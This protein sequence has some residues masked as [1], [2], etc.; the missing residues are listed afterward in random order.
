M[1]RSELPA[2]VKRASSWFE[3]KRADYYEYFSRVLSSSGGRIKPRQILQKD[4]DRFAGKPRGTL[5]QHWF[6]R[7]EENGGDLSDAFE[8][9]FPDDE[10]AVLRIAQGQGEGSLEKALLDMAKIA[11][12][13]QA[14]VKEVKSTV[15][16][17]FFGL[18]LAALMATLFPI[19]VATD[20]RKNYGYIPLEL[21]GPKAKTL[22]AYTDFLQAWGIVVLILL[23]A[24]A[25][26]FKWSLAG[27]IGELRTV[28]DRKIGIYR[29]YRDIKCASFMTTMATLTARNGTKSR[30]MLQAIELFSQSI[31]TP[32]LSWRVNATRDLIEELGGT[33]ADSFRTPMISDD[34]FYYLQDMQEASGLEKGFQD[35]ARYIDDA[36]IPAL[37]VRLIFYRYLI[38]GFA[39]ALIIFVWASNF[40]IMREMVGVMKM[41]QS[42]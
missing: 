29:T 13:Q 18:I 7:I 26:L 30:T 16:V 41:F 35:T 21:W 17:A 15:Y 10:I 11:R 27:W 31:R 1:N 34:I 23:I 33:T 36:L 20:N 32:W 19:Y 40:A 39:I 22:L 28:A 8:G 9:T 3:S 12:Q 37:K 2:S 25:Y 6:D 14:I 4:I 24:L 38:L 42:S 5:S